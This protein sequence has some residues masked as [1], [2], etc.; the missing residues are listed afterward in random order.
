MNL[1]YSL[2]GE[3]ADLQQMECHQVH[4]YGYPYLVPTIVIIVIG[5][6]HTTIHH[7]AKY[8]STL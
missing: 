1:V 8:H 2:E 4:D 7:G 3:E 5:I 6:F